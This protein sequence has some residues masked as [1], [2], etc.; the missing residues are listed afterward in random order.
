MRNQNRN[1]N[2][3]RNQAPAPIRVRLGLVVQN[4][5]D[6]S[7]KVVSTKNLKVAAKLAGTADEDYRFEGDVTGISVMVD[8][9]NGRIIEGL[10]Y[11]DEASVP[12]N[13]P[14]NVYDYLMS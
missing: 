12:A 14:T 6:G 10:D 8:P 7:V 11:E 3:N 2:Q 9:R 1:N 4:Q 5:G 13:T